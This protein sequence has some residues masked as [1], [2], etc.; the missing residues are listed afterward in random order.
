MLEGMSGEGCSETAWQWQ[1]GWGL[2]HPV[3]SLPSAFQP[4]AMW[5]RRVHR[6]VSPGIMLKAVWGHCR[7]GAA[8]ADSEEGGISLVVIPIGL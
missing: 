3:A 8:E 1:M 7:A 2:A 6:H 5:T 4:P